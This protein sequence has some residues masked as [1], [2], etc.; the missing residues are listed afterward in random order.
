MDHCISKVL[1]TE[2]RVPSSTYRLQMFETFTFDDA[3]KI[4]AYLKKL[5]ISDAYLSPIFQARP[6]STHGYDVMRHDR[7]N[8]E[9]GG[10]LAFDRFSEALKSA[11]MGLLLD[12]VPNHMG[13][14]NDA[15]WWQDVLANGRASK[16]ARYFDID[17]EPLKPDMQNK[18]LLPTLGTQYGEAL[19][20][21]QIQV[22]VADGSAMITYFENRFPIAPRT[23]ALLFAP[24]AAGQASIPEAL[25]AILRELQEVPAMNSTEDEAKH[26]RTRLREILPRLKQV[27]KAP[28]V[29]ELLQTVIPKINGTIGDVRSFDALHELLE[30]Q[31]Y[32]LASWRT[33]S[34]QIN[35][36]R[37]FDV[38]DL[39]GL[40]MEEP[41]VFA[42]T[43]SLI[44]KLLSEEKVTG[45]RVDHCDGMFN[46]RAYLE[47][48]QKLFVAAKCYGPVA[49]QEP[50]LVGGIEQKVLNETKDIDWKSAA[51]PLYCVVEKI[52]EPSENLP[53]IWAVQGTSGYDFLHVANQFFIQEKNKKRFDQIYSS[54][55]R[56]QPM[57]P[58]RVVYES[59]RNVMF[60]SLASETHVLTNLL[61]QIA[62]GDRRFRDFT[63]NL[64]ET[65]IR[66]T[67]ACF[68]IYRTYVDEY[69]NYSNADAT[70]IRLAIRLAKRRNPDV[71][72]SVFDYLQK[73]LL[74]EDRGNGNEQRDAAA[75]QFALK[76]QQLTGPVMAKGV[77]D[78]SLYVYVRFIS[79]N[80]VGSAMDAFG[81]SA[82]KLHDANERRAQR[83]PHSMLTT[84]THDT[85]RSEDVRNRLNVLSEMPDKWQAL[86][87][88][89]SQAN[90]V[91]KTTLDDGAIAP[92]SNEEYLIYQTI[93]GAWPW[94]EADQQGFPERLKSYVAKALS[95]AK[96]NVTW[97]NPRPEYTEAVQL[98]VD[99]LLKPGAG[100]KQSSFVRELEDFIPA[101]KM[102]GA[103]NSL[104]QLVLKATSPGVPDF[105][106]GCEMWD[107]SLV[108]PDNRRPVDYAKRSKAL[109]EFE[110]LGML[111]SVRQA[112]DDLGS[113]RIKLLTMQRALIARNNQVLASTSAEYT[114]LA[115]SNEEHLF[116]YMRGD[117]MIV[118]I[119]RFTYT[120][121]EGQP[122]WPIG[123]YWEG[124]SIDVPET[125]NGSWI[126]SLTGERYEITGR[127]LKASETFAHIPVAILIRRE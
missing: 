76:F 7:V 10:Q 113:G 14:G 121:T 44:R 125:A 104:A 117:D 108:D 55:L 33:S 75:L 63:D 50:L 96:I 17:W 66:E 116:A 93:V 65:A 100:E 19:E 106:Q 61:A 57:D 30:A 58:S 80:E 52:L 95:E 16:F 69:G 92:S 34:E 101:I 77:E 12:I 73:V 23:I 126:N 20:A 99:R 27:L 53:K 111:D 40:R 64:L 118:V 122:T 98:F 2:A 90:E 97:I 127:L 62:R 103:V 41:E 81:I 107:L 119:P 38:N 26:R 9:L 47:R 94:H 83:T 110:S 25:Q 82:T 68:P 124:H 74:L 109:E 1:T 49:H 43:H 87:S 70:V 22:E 8:P 78:T 6:H 72:F 51:L 71:D 48:L 3:T 31:P 39:V 88:G 89:W 85:K 105:Y 36:R 67:I 42:R 56:G 11:G 28:E 102:H 91:H 59:K 123:K 54:F 79:S 115:V 13:I 24:Y 114:A 29:A 35:Y 86:I 60:N 18:L 46:P 15:D 5:G 120:L 21:K 4:V 112:T 45:L 84:S 32:R 37:F